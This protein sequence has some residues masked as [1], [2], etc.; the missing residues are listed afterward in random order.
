[1]SLA[2]LPTD[3]NAVV[4]QAKRL[5]A[6]GRVAYD[7]GCGLV[8]KVEYLPDPDA[9][10]WPD[11]R[12]EAEL[13]DAIKDVPSLARFFAPVLDADQRGEWLVMLRLLNS[14]ECGSDWWG[15]NTFVQQQIREAFAAAGWQVYLSDLHA[16]NWGRDADGELR[17]LDYGFCCVMDPEG[18]TYGYQRNARRLCGSDAF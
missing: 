9:P 15:D 1:M 7:L 12:C 3:V 2:F 4:T 6:G 14:K 16:G 11:N 10:Y 18:K 13:W 17:I 5:G 8:V